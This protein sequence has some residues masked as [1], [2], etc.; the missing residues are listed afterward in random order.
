MRMTL[1][2]FTKTL[3]FLVLFAFCST[4]MYGQKVYKVNLK[5]D[6]GPNAWRTI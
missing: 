5:E 2:K 3:L 4:N 1:H 6:V